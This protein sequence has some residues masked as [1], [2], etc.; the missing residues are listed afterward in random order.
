MNWPNFHFDTALTG[1]NPYESVLSAANVTKLVLD[2]QSSITGG[3]PVVADGVIYA[4]SGG[5]TLYALNANTGDV[6]W[7]YQPEHG[8]TW[9]QAAAVV[10]GVVYLGF[11]DG[12]HGMD[13]SGMYAFNAH[14]GLLL[15]RAP[16]AGA[17]SPTMANGRVYFGQGSYLFALDAGSGGPLWAQPTGDT[18]ASPPTV[19]NGRVYFGSADKNVYALDA[20]TGALLWSYTTGGYVTSSPAVASGLV[21]IYSAA[22]GLY[23]LDANTGALRWKY[24][25][26]G[27]VKPT[28]YI[29]WY[30]PAVAKGVV[31]MGNGD[32]YLYALNASTGAMIWK[33]S[34]GDAPGIAVANGVVYA[35]NPENLYALDAKTGAYLLSYDGYYENSSPAVANGKVYLGSISAIQVLHLPEQ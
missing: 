13:T 14:T 12:P 32:A 20:I 11:D 17:V 30:S 31:Y 25:S 18:I 16:Y 28:Q 29:G 26:Q 35:S 4:G 6:L 21:Y 23:A 3:M 33:F 1:C 9:G 7:L 5:D 22:D 15:W 10:N 34:V 27:T 19:V 8:G 2:W 24:T